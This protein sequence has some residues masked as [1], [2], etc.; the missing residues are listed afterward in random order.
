LLA[1]RLRRAKASPGGSSGITGQIRVTCP[2]LFPV[3]LFQSRAEQALVS[4]REYGFALVV[5]VA[6][7]PEGAVFVAEERSA[8]GVGLVRVG[9]RRV[10]RDLLGSGPLSP[11]ASSVRMVCPSASCQHPPQ[12]I[13]APRLYR[14]KAGRA[15]P[16]TELGTSWAKTR[17]HPKN[18]K[19]FRLLAQTK[20]TLTS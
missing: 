3:W 5:A 4:A 20:P 17:F 6:M 7:I 19:C 16:P 10:A 15:V 1:W 11:R 9:L 12:I 2:I 18:R 13:N 14:L 8:D